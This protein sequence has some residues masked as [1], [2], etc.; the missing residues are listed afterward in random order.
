LEQ[1]P[2]AEHAVLARGGEVAPDAAAPKTTV[3]KPAKK[4]EKP[5]GEKKE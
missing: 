2:E 3:K 4:L 1:A 5:E